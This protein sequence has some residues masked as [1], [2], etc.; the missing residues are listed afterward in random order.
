MP[1]SWALAFICLA[2]AFSEPA[3]C[4]AMATAASLPE[5]SMSPYSRSL[6]VHFSPASRCM[7]E[8]YILLKLTAFSETVATSSRRPDS[9]ANMQVRILMVLPVEHCSSAF[10][11]IP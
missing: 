10:F 4:S 1:S 6:I 8:L 9:I 2:K 3:R 5:G 7:R 11:S